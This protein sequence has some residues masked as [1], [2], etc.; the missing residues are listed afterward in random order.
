MMEEMGPGRAAQEDALVASESARPPRAPPALRVCVARGSRSRLGLRLVARD[1]LALLE[2]VDVPALV[3]QDVE[4]AVAPH[5]ARR[6][7]H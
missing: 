4:A 6:A 7:G 3:R 1:L 5:R 2:P